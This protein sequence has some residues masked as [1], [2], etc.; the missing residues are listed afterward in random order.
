MLPPTTLPIYTPR[1]AFVLT[2][3]VPDNS[4][5]FVCLNLYLCGV[6]RG[7]E[8]HVPPCI[9]EIPIGCRSVFHGSRL[10]SLLDLSGIGGRLLRQ[11][12]VSE[13]GRT[14]CVVR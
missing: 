13:N 3:Y 9:R 10:D 1:H 14:C 2:G 8:R 12:A 7:D 11:A 6:H 5:R 4:K